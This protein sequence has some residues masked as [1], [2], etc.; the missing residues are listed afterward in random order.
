MLLSSRPGGHLSPG[1]TAHVKAFWL[2]KDERG[3]QDPR[4]LVD[5]RAY[6]DRLVAEERA[7]AMLAA[8]GVNAACL[9]EQVADASGG[10][11]LYL[12]HYAKGLRAGD[13]SLLKAETLPRGLYGIYGHFLGE[14]RRRRGAVPWDGAYKRVLGTLAVAGEP[15][16]RRQIA[17]FARVSQTTAGSILVR[18]KPFLERQG[19]GDRRRYTYYHTSFAEYVVSGENEDYVEARWSHVRIVTF[20]GKRYGGDQLALVSQAYARRHLAGGRAH[21]DDRTRRCL[22]NRQSEGPCRSHA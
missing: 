6:V 20:F 2:S 4:T 14:I 21:L 17:Q 8:R 10:N 7:G 1:L 19:R 18:L 9:A 13:K 12:H 3:R 11:F 15:L 16:N 22:P 5:A